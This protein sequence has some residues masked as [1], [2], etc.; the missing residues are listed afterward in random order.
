MSNLEFIKPRVKKTR[1]KSIKKILKPSPFVKGQ[2]PNPA[3]T[4]KNSK[5]KLLFEFF[6]LI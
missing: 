5:P 3:N 6:D 2:N 1:E 4:I